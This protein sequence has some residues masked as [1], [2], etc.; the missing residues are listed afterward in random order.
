MTTKRIIKGLFVLLTYSFATST[1][2]G[3]GS[4]ITKIESIKDFTGIARLSEERRLPILLMFSA[5][6]CGY[7]ERLEEDFLKPML[8]SGDY[9]DKVLIR[10]FKISGSG[11]VRDFDGKRIPISDFRSR[12]N[13]SVTPTV[14]F[15]DSSG[16]QLAPKRVGL[17]TPDFYGGYLDQ[18]IETALNVLRRS[19][20]LR[21]E[22]TSLESR[23]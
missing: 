21:V 5:D 15:L 16:A 3:D 2:G 18:S 13:I 11:E 17:T 10:K 12:Y 14:V 20:P 6:H 4:K 7:C 1:F 22:L 23:P 19:K 9:E 8:R